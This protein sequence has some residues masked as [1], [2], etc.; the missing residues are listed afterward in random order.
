M[1]CCTCYLLSF[2][3]QHHTKMMVAEEA[4]WLV[5]T[6]Q[7]SMEI[8]AAE[9]AKMVD[10]IG[11]LQNNELK[12]QIEDS[13]RKV[14]E[15]FAGV[16]ES[17]IP[18]MRGTDFSI[19]SSSV[20]VYKNLY[21]SATILKC[22]ELR[23]A[24]AMMLGALTLRSNIDMIEIDYLENDLVSV[25]SS[26]EYPNL[27]S[28]DQFY[29]CLDAAMMSFNSEL[30]KNLILTLDTH[31]LSETKLIE[32]NNFIDGYDWKDDVLEEIDNSYSYE[33]KRMF[34]LPGKNRSITVTR[35]DLKNERCRWLI[36]LLFEINPNI[37]C[38]LD[39]S[40][41]WYKGKTL[42]IDDFPSSIRHL[43]FT[44]CEKY[45][46]IGNDFLPNSSLISV[47]FSGFKNVT[48]IGFNLLRKCEFLKI[49][50]L[51]GLDNVTTIHEGFLSGCES[52]TSILNFS[53]FSKVTSIGNKFL[54]GCLSL[55]SVDI[56]VLQSVTSI[57][58]RF[59][60]NCK[61]LKIV[62]LCN[63]DKVTVIGDSFLDRCES[64]ASVDISVLQNVTSIGSQFLRHCKK[65]ESV[66]LSIIDKVTDIGDYFLS[67][68]E[69]LKDISNFSG[70]KTVKTIGSDFLFGC[71]SLASVDISVLQSVTS[72][73]SRFLAKCEKLESVDLSSFDKVTNIGD[74][75]LGYCMSL[76]EIC[77][78]A[79]LRN[80]KTIGSDFLFG[81]VC[82][83]SVDI[84][85]LRSSEKIG[86][87]FLR[88]CKTLASVNLCSFEKVTDIGDAFLD[89][90]ESLTDISNISGLR[91]VKSI[92]S[93]FLFGCRSLPS[94]DISVLQNVTSIGSR[95]LAKCEKLESVD[96]SS[97]DKV[98]NIGDY[99]LRDCRSLKGISNISGLR[100][101]KS[102]GSDYLSECESLA[103]LEEYC[104]AISELEIK[105]R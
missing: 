30:K 26:P 81:C 101:I 27:H 83:T 34:K 7:R 71:V 10:L 99:F 9:M 57:G 39:V 38:V 45:L 96:L 70:L 35:N 58:S 22:E 16:V 100:N 11:D 79:G 91:N 94:V 89:Q 84:S 31:R 2:S 64:L 41:Q 23:K 72:I 24:T 62:D 69:S 1:F 48:A 54:C 4:R 104:L 77:N 18:T 78:M 90:C 55:A 20:V 66:D 37:E 17:S 65:I 15:G 50:N 97:F 51:S 40:G 68:C 28:E 93:D 44:N 19:T 21:Q 87:W 56:S 36:S 92:G 29:E 73:G 60:R 76:K 59:L 33:A 52:L 53:V 61:K 32:F 82:L 80:V 14:L 46:S 98:T 42:N 75:F 12:L 102:I 3:V 103:S 88:D 86:P 85:V 6:Q 105:A 49:V 67:S 8:T 43:S 13:R 25:F 5:A 95:F 47:D 74:Y 63:F